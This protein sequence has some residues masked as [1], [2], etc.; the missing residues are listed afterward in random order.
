MSD[1][2]TQIKSKRDGQAAARVRAAHRQ[3]PAVVERRSARA[4]SPARSDTSSRSVGSQASSRASSRASSSRASSSRASDAS[5][6]HG[7][8]ATRISDAPL[9][10]VGSVV[11]GVVSTVLSWGAFV[12][13]GVA[14][15]GLLHA[16][17]AHATGGWVDNLSD[18]IAVGDRL[19]LRVIS[20]DPESGKFTLS[21][22]GVGQTA[23]H[24]SP[25]PSTPTASREQADVLPSHV[26][27][28]AA[29]EGRTSAAVAETE[30]PEPPAIRVTDQGNEEASAGHAPLASQVVLGVEAPPPPPPSPPEVVLTRKLRDRVLTL[31]KMPWRHAVDVH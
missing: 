20:V 15:D 5:T 29:A 6:R 24:G 13:C 23:P 16:R 14:K 28:R 26:S 9:P 11:S 10:E 31:Y 1:G 17:E 2:W 25:P 4:S 12:R 27:S 7:G 22:R 19:D 18:I 30:E 8:R 21:R 3:A